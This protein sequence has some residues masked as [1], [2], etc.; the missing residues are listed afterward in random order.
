MQ[1]TCPN[2]GEV[3]NLDTIAHESCDELYH[4]SCAGLS[5]SDV[6]RLDLNVPYICLSCNEN[7]Y[8]SLS[9]NP[10]NEK[11]G[12]KINTY[13][14]QNCHNSVQQSNL[15]SNMGTHTRADILS[16]KALE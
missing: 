16:S 2:C 3:V 6:N 5:K 8:Y 15:I 9:I 14:E 12:E 11:S 10:S 4:Y 7:L 1:F 13:P